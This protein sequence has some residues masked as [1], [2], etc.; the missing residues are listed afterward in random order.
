MTHEEK[1]SLARKIIKL[2]AR[3]EITISDTKEILKTAE[4][5]AEQTLVRGSCA[6]NFDDWFD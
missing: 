5:M 1:L 6:D 2:L 3:H 4:K